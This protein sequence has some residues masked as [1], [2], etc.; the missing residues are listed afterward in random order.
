M[1]TESLKSAITALTGWLVSD[2]TALD[3]YET[4]PECFYTRDL[5]FTDGEANFI[6]D[7]IGESVHVL[8]DSITFG[9]L[10]ELLALGGFE[11]P[12]LTGTIQATPESFH[13]NKELKVL[14]ISCECTVVVKPIELV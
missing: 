10:D 2:V 12:E 13:F 7:N 3:P 5:I 9:E 1:S 6:K 8:V 11:Q 14:L 4:D